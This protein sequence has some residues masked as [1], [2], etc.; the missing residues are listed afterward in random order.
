M[1][2]LWYGALPRDLVQRAVVEAVGYVGRNS[3]VHFRERSAV[4]GEGLR[5]NWWVIE[6]QNLRQVF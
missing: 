4:E 3:R 1:R 5:A 2:R 6:H